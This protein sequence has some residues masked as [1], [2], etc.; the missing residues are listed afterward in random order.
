MNQYKLHLHIPNKTVTVEGELTTTDSYHI[1]KDGPD[2]I[3]GD[4]PTVLFQA[5]VHN[6]LYIQLIRPSTRD[7]E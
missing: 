3:F 6:V 1:I 2:Y 7:S 4:Q 5:P